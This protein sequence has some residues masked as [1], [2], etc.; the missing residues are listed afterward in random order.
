MK[1]SLIR[2]WQIFN[3]RLSSFVSTIKVKGF[4]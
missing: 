2:H 4:S 3:V 1:R